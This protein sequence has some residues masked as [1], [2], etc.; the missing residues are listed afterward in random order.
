MQL[1]ST[2]FECW[3]WEVSQDILLLALSITT[4]AYCAVH[5]IHKVSKSASPRELTPLF[6]HCS[7]TT[8]R[9]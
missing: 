4:G 8:R 6:T 9:C 3:H 7:T 1:L 2:A 5:C